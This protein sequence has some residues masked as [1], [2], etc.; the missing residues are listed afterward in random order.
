MEKGMTLDIQQ[1]DKLFEICRGIRQM[2]ENLMLIAI[3]RAETVDYRIICSNLHDTANRCRTE[4]EGIIGK[5]N[6]C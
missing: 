6:Y 3:D 4:L 5:V 1:V 2:Q